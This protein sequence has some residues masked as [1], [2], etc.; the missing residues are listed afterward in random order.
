MRPRAKCGF[1]PVSSTSH[2][3]WSCLARESSSPIRLQDGLMVLLGT[4]SLR[5]TSRSMQSLPLSFL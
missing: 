5:I 1:E 2:C 4:T 3:R